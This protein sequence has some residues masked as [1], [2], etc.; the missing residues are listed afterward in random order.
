MAKKRKLKKQGKRGVLGLLWALIGLLVRG[1]MRILPVLILCAGAWGLFFGLK[2]ILYRD[3][4]FA[5][6]S[7]RVNPP[8]DLA[9]SKRQALDARYLGKNILQVNIREIARQLEADPEIEWA[10]VRKAFP[11]AISVEIKRRIP[12]AFLR[13]SPRGDYGVVSEDG[14]ILD[15][16]EKPNSTDLVIDAFALG[17]QKPVIGLQIKNKEFREAVSFI[18]TYWKDPLYEKEP[19][20]ALSLDHLGNVTAILSKGPMIRLGRKPLAR[21]DAMSKLIALLKDENRDAIDYVDLQ[22]DD[23]V[24]KRKGTKK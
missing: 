20:A 13:L 18:K 11:S 10:H 8:Q 19:V 1:L 22:Y 2:K 24:I 21:L 23:V 3:T 4:S 16:V 7:I 17:V 6:Q 15:V 5:V 9:A 14:M 12:I